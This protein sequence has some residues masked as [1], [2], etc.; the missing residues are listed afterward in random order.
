MRN[1]VAV[2][3]LSQGKLTAALNGFH[4]ALEED[5]GF[6]PAR[7][8]LAHVY[9]RL[10]RFDEAIHEY[11]AVI[12][13]QPNNFLAHNNLGV[14]L[15]K[16]GQYDQAIIEFTDA[17]RSRPGDAMAQRNLETAKKNM[18]ILQERQLEIHRAEADA[19][20]KPKDATA[21]YR[22]AQVHAAYGNKALV[23]QWLERSLRQGYE[24]A[25]V[26]TD[27]V[28]VNLRD[29]RDFELLLLGK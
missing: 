26:K 25:R 18:A 4:Q 19:Q 10:N 20:A 23:L 21:S 11:R 16:N 28:F 1:D 2:Q 13:L 5:P 24:A 9:E 27:P 15:D 7:L 14:L 22:A 29:D 8:Y 17:L 3:L 12:T 6:L